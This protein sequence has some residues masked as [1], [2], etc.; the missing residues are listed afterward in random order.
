MTLHDAE[1]ALRAAGHEV[2]RCHDKVPAN[3]NAD[4][5]AISSKPGYVL[6]NCQAGVDLYALMGLVPEIA[7]L[8][9]VK[10]P[11]GFQLYYA[12][13][14]QP[15]QVLATNKNGTPRIT[16]CEYAVTFPTE[17]Y[18]LEHGLLTRIPLKD[19]SFWRRL[20]VA[21]SFQTVKPESITPIPSPLPAVVPDLEAEAPLVHRLTPVNDETV[22]LI[23]QTMNPTEDNVALV[24]QDRFKDELR[25]CQQWGRW[26]RWNE[27]KWEADHTLLAFHY[28]REIARKVNQTKGASAP[29]KASFARGVEAFVRS[30]R[31]FATESSHW[32]QNYWLLNVPAGT[33]DL[34]TGELRPHVKSDHITK[35]AAV[36]PS[37]AT[38]PVFDRFMRDITLEDGDLIEYLQRAL[39]ACL[40]GAVQD[41]FLLFWYGDQGQN[42]KNTLSELLAFIIGDYADFIP[43]ETLMATKHAQHLTFLASLRGLRVAVCSEVSEGSYWNEQRIKSL[44]GD[45]KISANYMRQDPFSFDRTHKHI[46]LGNHRPM[47]RIVDPAIKS[48]LHIVPFRAHFDEDTKDPEMGM[49]LRTEAPAILQWL[50]D[51]HS[52]WLEDGRILKKCSAVQAETESYFAAQSTNEM[53]VEECCREGDGAE[54]QAKEL[55][56][57]FKNWKEAR[58]EGVPS[59]T[60][61]S[62][63]ASNRYTKRKSHGVMVYSGIE[64]KPQSV[65][66]F[67]P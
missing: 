21:C 48:R 33:V 59:Q 5:L 38:R 14:V 13:E 28:C 47:L 26:L 36:S 2:L 32:D 17:G 29:S 4:Q 15:P 64:L 10:T 61:W 12:G 30:S 43:T 20:K 23:Y 46:V 53:W 56:M 24:F 16:V 50:I 67:K 54:G 66:D 9:R 60:R 31:V 49:K 35:C 22:E 34:L 45:A 55:Y 1:I 7:E 57:S 62:E 6:I 42:G 40:S 51:G 39:G 37:D 19:D 25:Y 52:R 3:G 18:T 63:W 8:T 41:N 58:G 44:T 65:L 27:S 11:N